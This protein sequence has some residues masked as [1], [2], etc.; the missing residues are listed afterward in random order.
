MQVASLPQEIAQAFGI[1]TDVD[2]V[3]RKQAMTIPA[4]R[5]GRNVIA[6]KIGTAPLV[7]TRVRAGSAPERVD[8]PFF[9][10]PD[11]NCT[12]AALLTWTVDDLIFYGVSYWIITGRDAPRALIEAADLVTE[13]R[14]VKHPLHTQGIRAQKGIEF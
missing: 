4:V 1:N 14:E 7:C 8:R 12:R 6:G 5:Q 10:Q 3:T 11:P 9:N 2:F 13:M